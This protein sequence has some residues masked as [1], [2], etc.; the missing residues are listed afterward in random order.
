MMYSQARTESEIIIAY[1]CN[2][3]PKT[4]SLTGEP[5]DL[6]KNFSCWLPNHEILVCRLT[7]SLAK[8]WVCTMNLECFSAS[9]S[10]LKSA[11]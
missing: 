10:A 11:P 4:D 9:I 3:L 7:Q 6:V 5:R 1:T 8:L 2:D